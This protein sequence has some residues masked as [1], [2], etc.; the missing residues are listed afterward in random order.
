MSRE[1]NGKAEF[2]VNLRKT[3]QDSTKAFLAVDVF[4]TMDCGCEV[5][6]FIQAEFFKNILSTFRD[7]EVL[8]GCIDNRISCNKDFLLRDA[9]V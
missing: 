2:F 1:D 5:F 6:F 3:I 9:F 7:M 8:I 4:G